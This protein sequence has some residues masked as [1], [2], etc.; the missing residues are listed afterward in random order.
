MTN[1]FDLHIDSWKQ[2]NSRNSKNSNQG[3]NCIW[4]VCELSLFCI[5]LWNNSSKKRHFFKV[6]GGKTH[7]FSLGWFSF[8][9]INRNIFVSVITWY[10][11]RGK[12]RNVY[13]QHSVLS[14]KS[15][16]IDVFCSRSGVW[17]IA[18]IFQNSCQLWKF[19]KPNPDNPL[20]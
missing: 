13:P 14:E 7:R 11:A 12:R 2:R 9:Y 10:R 1:I 6:F 17:W 19:V 3:F 16:Q 20:P 5:Q 15:N 18:K 8:T 4:K